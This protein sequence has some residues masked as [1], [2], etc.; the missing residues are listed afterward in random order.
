M[1]RLSPLGP[2]PPVQRFRGRRRSGLAAVL[3]LAAAGLGL[4]AF[5]YWATA[6]R[7][8]AYDRLIWE[9]AR[10][11][12]VAPALVKAVIRQES[13]F[14]ARAVGKAGEIGLMQIR[15]GA[16]RD[17]ER[18]TKQRC[19]TSGLLFDPRLNVEIG[20]WYLARCLNRWRGLESRDALGLA[21]YNAGVANVLKWFPTPPVGDVLGGIRFGPTRRYIRNV[22]E[23]RVRYERDFREFQQTQSQSPVRAAHLAAG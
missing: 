12:G 1:I 3:V 4:I 16:V 11:A 10:R 9:A 18:V 7:E 19:P 13:N 6:H 22:F 17:W 15:L 8:H 2:N 14:D 5:W 21:Q 23:Y 20:T